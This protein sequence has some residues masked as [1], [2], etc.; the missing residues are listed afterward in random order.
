MA[1]ERIY[2]LLLLDLVMKR[3]RKLAPDNRLNWRDL[4]MP[5]L[6]YGKFQNADGSIFLGTKTV[7]PIHI[8]QYYIIKLNSASYDP[9]QW[10]D[11][12]SY[13]WRKK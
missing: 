2:N 4:N 6:R 8:Q 5:V 12:P 9:P 3:Q 13:W 7:E 10:R 1:N 11:D